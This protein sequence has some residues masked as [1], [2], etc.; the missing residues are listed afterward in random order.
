MSDKVETTKSVFNFNEATGRRSNHRNR[1]IYRPVDRKVV[2]GQQL[3]HPR[4][5]QNRRQE[6]RGDIPYEQPVAVL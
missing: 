5:I 2:G 3:L 6:P 1:S 4:L